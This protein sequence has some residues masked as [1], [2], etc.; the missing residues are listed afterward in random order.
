MAIEE[1]VVAVVQRII[2]GKHG[3][4]VVTTS[5]E[6]EGSITFSLRKEV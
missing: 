5:E 4:Y 1:T 6:I 2:E 3:R